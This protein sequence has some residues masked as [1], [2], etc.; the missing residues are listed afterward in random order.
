L[1]TLLSDLSTVK[2]QRIRRSVGDGFVY[3]GVK[4]SGRNKHMQAVIDLTMDPPV[5]DK[6]IELK[7]AVSLTTRRYDIYVG[8]YDSYEEAARIADN[9]DKSIE[10]AHS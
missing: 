7:Y 6:D 4:I 10:E 8:T 1:K 9:I 3:V 5:E 2:W